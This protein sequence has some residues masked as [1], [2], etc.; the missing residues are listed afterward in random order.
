MKTY[1]IWYRREPSFQPDLTLTEEKVKR[2]HVLVREIEAVDL[3]DA[4]WK[5]QGENWSPNGEARPLIQRL[6]LQHT[7]MSVGDVAESE[8]KFWQ[9]DFCGWNPVLDYHSFILN[10]LRVRMGLYFSVPA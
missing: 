6:G 7:S 9:V 4:Y 8:G 10:H 2:S 3:D 1:K 5:M